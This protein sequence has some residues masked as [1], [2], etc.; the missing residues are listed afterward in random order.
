MAGFAVLDE[1]KV[2]WS[3]IRNHRHAK[4]YEQIARPKLLFASNRRA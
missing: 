2:A 4:L 1:Y 3:Q